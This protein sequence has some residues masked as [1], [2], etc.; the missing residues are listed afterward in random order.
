MDENGSET[1]RDLLLSHALRPRTGYFPTDRKGDHWNGDKGQDG[2]GIGRPK[3]NA[4][5]GERAWQ[6]VARGTC[7]LFGQHDSESWRTQSLGCPFQKTVHINLNSILFPVIPL[8]KRTGSFKEQLAADEK[9]ELLE[10][11]DHY[12]QEYIPLIVPITL[13]QHYVRKYDQPHLKQQV[14]LNPHPLELQLRNH[15]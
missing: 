10:V 8:K 4:G 5:G 6:R 11:I 15:V 9:K 13:I 12:R 1:R 3:G 2:R 14:Y 7:G